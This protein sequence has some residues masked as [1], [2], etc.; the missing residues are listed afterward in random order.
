MR[1]SKDVRG[2]VLSQGGRYQRVF[3]KSKDGKAPSP[4]KV[5]GVS[6]G[7]KRYIACLSEEQA[8]KD[9]AVREASV[10]SL[11]EALKRGNKSLIGNKGYRRC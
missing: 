8:A 3:G 2:K 11:C 5:K 7:Q 6:I 4:L 10:G 1:K 9:R